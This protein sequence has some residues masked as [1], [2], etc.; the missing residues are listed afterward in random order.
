M[1]SLLQPKFQVPGCKAW[2]NTTEPPLITV[3]ESVPT[4]ISQQRGQERAPVTPTHP[5]TFMDCSPQHKD[6]RAIRVTWAQLPQNLV[7]VQL[8]S[9]PGPDAAGTRTIM[10][11]IGLFWLNCFLWINSWKWN[12]WVSDLTHFI[13]D[14]YCL[15]ALCLLRLVPLSHWTLLLFLPWLS[16]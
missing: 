8:L 2:W 14:S 7:P 13:S 16:Q 10:K 1:S 4:F 9:C 3:E 12:D 6:G 5:F 11:I 15:L